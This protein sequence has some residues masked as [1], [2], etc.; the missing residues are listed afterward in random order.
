MIAKGERIREVKRLVN[1]YGGRNSKWVKK[2]S[3][4]VVDSDGAVYE[5]HWYECYGIGILE[6]KRKKVS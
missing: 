5:F 3:P 6:I 2:S 4:E 1:M